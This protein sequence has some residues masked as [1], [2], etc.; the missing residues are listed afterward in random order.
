MEAGSGGKRPGAGRKPNVLKGFGFDVIAETW[1]LHKQ[2][3]FWYSMLYSSNERISFEAG[4]YLTDRM[5]G[6]AKQEVDVNHGISD[7][8]ALRIKEARER[9][10]RARNQASGSLG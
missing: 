5:Y 1:P 9:A 7:S 8:L 3:T 6:K 4:K 10:R 2:K